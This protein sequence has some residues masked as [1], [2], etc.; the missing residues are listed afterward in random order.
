MNE[1]EFTAAVQSRK[2]A[3]RVEADVARGLGRGVRGSPVLLVGEKR[4]DGVPG[5]EKLAELIAEALKAPVA[6][7]AP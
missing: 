2:C 4:I 6:G 7:S 1:A 5:L 3:L